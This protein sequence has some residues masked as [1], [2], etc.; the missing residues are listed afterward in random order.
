M[1]Q[2]LPNVGPGWATFPPPRSPPEL[3]QQ[4][5]NKTTK[6]RAHSSHSAPH[7]CGIMSHGS[8]QPSLDCPQEW[9]PP[10]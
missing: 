10:T 5:G 2:I 9:K 8:T 6:T 1:Q 7:A 3:Q 4:R